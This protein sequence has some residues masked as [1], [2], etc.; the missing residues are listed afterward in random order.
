MHESSEI[1]SFSTVTKRQLKLTVHELR[2][3]RLWW[4]WRVIEVKYAEH[5]RKPSSE[6]SQ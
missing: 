5:D 4:L 2:H 6:T 3:I 1:R